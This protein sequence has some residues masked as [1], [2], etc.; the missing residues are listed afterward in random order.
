MLDTRWVIRQHCGCDA[1]VSRWALSSRVTGGHLPNVTQQVG[2]LNPAPDLGLSPDGAK[3][4]LPPWGS[5]G[6]GRRLRAA[7]ATPCPSPLP[8][9]LCTASCVWLPKA[10]PVAA[11]WPPELNLAH[12]HVV[13]GLQEGLKFFK[14]FE[15]TF[16]NWESLH[17]KICIFG[18]Y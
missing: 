11:N 10:R 5:R 18:F 6:P 17:F 8:A 1:R 15:P 9:W 13:F 3:N 4:D 2:D 12:R 14:T 16:K 7:P